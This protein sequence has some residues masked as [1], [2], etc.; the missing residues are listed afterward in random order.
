MADY[1]F[2]V[3][4][5]NSG[6][7]WGSVWVCRHLWGSVGICG[8][9]QRSVWLHTLRHSA[10]WLWGPAS[11]PVLQPLAL[12]KIPSRTGWTTI[13]SPSWS[14]PQDRRTAPLRTL[15][16]TSLNRLSASLFAAIGV[17]ERQIAVLQDL[18]SLFLTSYRTKI[19]DYEKEYSL[20]QNPF[21][22]NIAPIPILPENSEQIWPKTLDAIDEVV[23]ER[24]CFVKKVRA[25]VENMDIRRKIV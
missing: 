5:L 22:K 6:E 20:R 23:Q 10:I 25:L 12:G 4:C 9:L 21:Y 11:S 13:H 18:H 19:K 16:L 17:A 2:S 15:L 7:E 1:R 14:Y 3:L 8:D 24:K